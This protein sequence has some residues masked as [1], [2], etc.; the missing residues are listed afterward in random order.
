MTARK[1][2]RQVFSKPLFSRP[3]TAQKKGV[4][5][6]WKA[7]VS[8]P[9]YIIADHRTLPADGSIRP[10]AFIRLQRIETRKYEPALGKP[11][12]GLTKVLQLY[13]SFA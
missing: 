9:S 11:P 10:G 6:A 13:I 1:L 7:G 2:A 3:K 12:S 8:T 5:R 4:F